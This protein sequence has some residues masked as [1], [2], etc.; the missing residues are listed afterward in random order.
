[1]RISIRLCSAVLTVGALTAGCSREEVTVSS[2]GQLPQHGSF[3]FVAAPDAPRTA[4]AALVA[5]RL[6]R[7][8]LHEAKDASYLVQ[9]A[10]AQRPVATGLFVPDADPTAWARA[11]R[12]AGKRGA[13]PMLLVTLSETSSGREVFRGVA[14]HGRVRDSLNR[15]AILVDALLGGVTPPAR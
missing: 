14:T 15:E 6:A 5:D 12:R 8:G 11:P 2:A 10:Y 7:G 4:L 9:A 13:A 1:M 3:A